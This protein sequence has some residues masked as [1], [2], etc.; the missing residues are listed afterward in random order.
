MPPKLVT[1]AARQCTLSS[2]SHQG[3][4][5]AGDQS[6]PARGPFSSANTANVLFAANHRRWPRVAAIDRHSLPTNK[7]VRDSSDCKQLH[8]MDDDAA[9]KQAT[10]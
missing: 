10:R 4:I 9:L 3:C 1:M 2:E 5:L 7:L 6:G 8:V